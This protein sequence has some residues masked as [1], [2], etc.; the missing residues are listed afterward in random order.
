MNRW[1]IQY[2]WE[3]YQEREKRSMEIPT[4]ILPILWVDYRSGFS[5]TEAAKKW[6]GE[7][8]TPFFR[9]ELKGGRDWQIS[10]GKESFH[11]DLEKV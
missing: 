3:S 6:L 4:H 5:N 9:K 8:L 7:S 10:N 2:K 1:T 11:V